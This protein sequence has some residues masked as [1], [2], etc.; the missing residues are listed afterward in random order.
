MFGCR[1]GAAHDTAA[2]GRRAGGLKLDAKEQVRKKRIQDLEAVERDLLVKQRVIEQR[3]LALKTY[4]VPPGDRAWLEAE[5]ALA[6]NKR[7][8]ASVRNELNQARRLT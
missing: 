8:L 7:E 4:R 3:K 2:Y 1:H 5:R 6:T